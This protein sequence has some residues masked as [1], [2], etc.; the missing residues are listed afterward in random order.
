[1]NRLKLKSFYGHITVALVFLM[2]PNFNMIDILPDFIGYFLIARAIGTLSELLPY[3][4]EAK[5]AFTN[6][7]FVTLAKLPAT[8]V[9]YANMYSGRDIVPLFTLTFTAIELGLLIKAVSSGASAL[10]YLGERSEAKSLIAPFRAFGKDVPVE[11]V[12]NGTL[13]FVIIK[14]SLNIIPQFCLL[15]YSTDNVELIRFLNSLFPILEISG[16]AICLAVGILW[17]VFIRKYLTLVK[18][19]GKVAEGI[20]ALIDGERLSEISAKTKAKSL[21]FT[22]IFLALSSLLSFELAFEETGNFNILPHFIYGIALTL[23]G[24][25]LFGEKRRRTLCIASAIYIIIGVVGQFFQGSFFSRFQYLDL[26]DSTAAQGAYLPVVICAALECLAF[27]WLAS[28]MALGFADFIRENTG[29]TLS[30]ENK[31]ALDSLHRTLSKKGYLLFG[32]AALVQVAKALNTFFLGQVTVRFAEGGTMLTEP[33]LSWFGVV[34]FVLTAVY[35]A[36]SLYYLSEVREEVKM[37]YES[38]ANKTI[39]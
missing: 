35:V 20:E 12:K 10:Y 25:K 28:V 27:L 23:V 17:F 37:K 30:K 38:E 39:K 14:A 7:G 21:N 32:I 26:Y 22:L 15:T 24:W 16:M 6:L 4:H 8:L 5:S 33:M 19:E 13:A 31:G 36:Y 18:S 11:A 34:V 3:F 29:A 9:M 2:N 1:M